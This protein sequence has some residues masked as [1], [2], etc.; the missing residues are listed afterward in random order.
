VGSGSWCDCEVP[1]QDRCPQLGFD[2]LE[3]HE[4][5]AGA[6]QHRPPLGGADVADPVRVVTEHGHD[7]SLTLMLGHDHGK[8]DQASGTPSRDL[9][10]DG[11]GWRQDAG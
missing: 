11:S 2:L 5:A 7:V 9:E 1:A 3:L 8:R 10:R 4:L 6:V